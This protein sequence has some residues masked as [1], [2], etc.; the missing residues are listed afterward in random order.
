LADI[1]TQKF[2]DHTPL[3]RIREKLSR[4][5]ISI[6]RQQLSQWV[7]RI[8]KELTPLY[9]L[10]H[11]KILE[12]GNIFAD[13]SPV[14]LL[15]SGRGKTHKAYM[16]VVAGG[17]SKDPPYRIYQFH[18]NRKHKHVNDLIGK[19]YTGGLHSDKYG[20]YETLVVKKTIYLV[21]LLE[22]CAEKVF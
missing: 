14:E 15:E 9:K 19:N 16:W 8:G 17:Q 6:S 20:C 3:Y 13:E 11:Q 21:S 12:S 1:L 4:V 10:M 5:E 22:P 18:L 7:V 2:A